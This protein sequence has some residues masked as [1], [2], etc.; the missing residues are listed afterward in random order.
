MYEVRSP[1][2]K[3]HTLMELNKN[4]E[5]MYV[6][7][8]MGDLGSTTTTG[9]SEYAIS[10][11]SHEYDEGRRG[12]VSIEKIRN[13]GV[14]PHM[15]KVTSVD[16][17]TVAVQGRTE[18]PSFTEERMHRIYRFCIK[19]W[20]A[21]IDRIKAGKMAILVCGQKSPPPR[22]SSPIFIFLP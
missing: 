7:Q 1:W 16:S 12:K 22:T 18:I 8:N 3:S 6:R 11:I 4:R 14:Q 2:T 9:K 15:K 5:V 13:R 19:R 17:V 21:R 20:V 10:F